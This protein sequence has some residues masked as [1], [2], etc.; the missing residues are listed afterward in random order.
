MLSLALVLSWWPHQRPKYTRIGGLRMGFYITG[1]DAMI[2]LTC[3]NISSHCWVQRNLDVFLRSW[4]IGLIISVSLGMNW[5]NVVNFTTNF[6]TSFMFF[7]LHMSMM[8]WHLLGLAS[9]LPYV[10]MNMRN[11]P[12]LISNTHFLGFNLMLLFLKASKT[13]TRLVA[14]YSHELDLTTMSYT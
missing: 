2:Y 3:V 4:M 7:G 10:S 5:D 11:F 8:V 13:F 6:W 14:Y 9:I 12:P 1:S